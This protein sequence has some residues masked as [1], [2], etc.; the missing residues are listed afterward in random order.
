MG[1]RDPKTV[2]RNGKRYVL[3]PE[4][5]YR[6]LTDQ[7]LGDAEPKLPAADASGHYPAVET[8]RVILAGKI[9]GRRKALGLTQVDLARRAGVRVE[10]LSRLEHAKHSP[11]IRTVDKIDRALT[12]A[13]AHAKPTK[14]KHRKSG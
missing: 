2:T 7:V 14:A 6:A 8:V 4:A 5:E 3:V 12:Q 13:E 1:R 10:T 11:S 9:I